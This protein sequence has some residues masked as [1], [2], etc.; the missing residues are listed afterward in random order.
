M[1]TNHLV[2]LNDGHTMPRVGLGVYQIPSEA[3]SAAV[4]TALESGY[5]HVDTASFYQ[6]EDG[7]G[8]GLRW[9]SLARE[10]MFVTTKLWN[11]EQGY[12]NALRACEASLRR[13]GLDYLDLYLIH[14]PAP[15]RN[16]YVETWRAFVRLREQG[17]VRSIGV[18]NFEPEHLQRLIEE[19]GVTPTVNQIELH[20]DFQQRA[21]REAHAKLGIVTES[22][23]PLG[24]GSLLDHPV[25][26]RIAEKHDRTPAQI[27]I[28]WHLQNDL[29]VIPKSQS[30]QRISSN[31]D[32][33]DFTLDAEDMAQ[34]E[35]L[36]SA[37]ARIGPD[38][39]TFD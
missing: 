39:K 38:P 28:R 29:V 33:F 12:D 1:N 7:V 30:P 14:W 35:G 21:L 23:S 15:Q 9:S 16:Q 2:K 22:W 13:L 36:D 32:V 11:D 26:V 27:I 4:A 5:R 17:L 18:S 10:D 3:T 37:S 8:E 19:T 20:T 6:N 24:Q 25:I 31:F 34:L